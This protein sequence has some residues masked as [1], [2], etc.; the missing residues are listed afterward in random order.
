MDDSG[1]PTENLL[2]ICSMA[3][4][5][6]TGL[7][8]LRW[9]GLSDGVRERTEAGSELLNRSY[10]LAGLGPSAMSARPRSGSMRGLPSRLRVAYLDFNGVEA[11]LPECLGKREPFVGLSLPI[12]SSRWASSSSAGLDSRLL[13]IPGAYSN[14]NIAHLRQIETQTQPLFKL[15]QRGTSLPAM[16]HATNIGVLLQPR[17]IVVAHPTLLRCATLSI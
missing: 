5:V 8:V 7:A 4:S 16:L 10:L 2:F 1:E 15:F 13:A 11:G 9:C 14:S 6:E 3:S 12:V 17:T